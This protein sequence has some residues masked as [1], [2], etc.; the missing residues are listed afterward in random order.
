[1][2]DAPHE[3]LRRARLAAGFARPSEAAKTFQW[4]EPTYFAHENG[5]R[6]I[7]PSAAKRYARAFNVE[8]SWILLGEGRG[9]VEKTAAETAGRTTKAPG[10]AE[11]EAVR[12]SNDDRSV[13]DEVDAIAVEIAQL[14]QRLATLRRRLGLRAA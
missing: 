14:E 10:A 2:S 8:S 6:G 11:P 13:R 12:Y 9:V 7:R 4:P 3:R 5:S 1:M